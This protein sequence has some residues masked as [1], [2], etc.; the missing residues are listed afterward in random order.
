ME[1]LRRRAE[2]R[3]DR[4]EIDV[5]LGPF[6]F[7]RL[8]EEVEQRGLPAGGAGKQESAAAQAAEDRFRDAGRRQRRQRGIEGVTAVTQDV[9]RGPGGLAVTGR[10][11]SAALDLCA[12]RSAADTKVDR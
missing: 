5:G 9:G 2:I 10:H 3:Q 1:F 6:A 4:P 8:G 12:H 7:R 11:D